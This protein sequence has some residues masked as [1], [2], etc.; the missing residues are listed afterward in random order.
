MFNKSD[1]SEKTKPNKCVHFITFTNPISYIFAV[2]CISADHF[3]NYNLECRNHLKI[4]QILFLS[5]ISAD[6]IVQ[7]TRYNRYD[8]KCG[9]KL[10]FECHKVL[11]LI[12]ILL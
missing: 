8:L 9:K 12:T 7:L 3:R 10:H 4:L 6:T 5:K 11:Y 1:R 2:K